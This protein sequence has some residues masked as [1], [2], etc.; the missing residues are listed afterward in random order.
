MAQ[1]THFGRR[2]GATCSPV[3]SWLKLD[4]MSVFCVI[5]YEKKSAV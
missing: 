2:E 3:I 5:R 4:K 1:N